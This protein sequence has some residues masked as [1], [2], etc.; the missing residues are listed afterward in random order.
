MAS[1]G[2]A[3]VPAGSD[4]F[5]VL[6]AR[7]AL[8]ILAALCCLIAL[9][10]WTG[11]S[12]PHTK[13]GPPSNDSAV[14][15][16]IV[17][18]LQQGEDYYPAALRE[19][20][21]G[22]Y[23]LKPFLTVRLPTLALAAAALP[24]PAV[25]QA[26]AG[27]LAL[28]T[29]AAWLW[30]LRGWMARPFSF[31]AMVVV[32]ILALVPAPIGDDYTFHELWCG[33]LMALALAVYSP[34][35][36]GI[37]FVIACLALSLRELT[38][39]FFLAMG[40]LAWRDGRRAEAGA[41]GFAL[42]VFF[43]ALALHAAAVQPWVKPDDPPSAGWLGLGGWQFLLLLTKWNF[44]LMTAPDWLPAVLLPLA[45]FGLIARRGSWQDRLALTVLGYSFTFLVV[46]RADNS[47]WGLL[48][49]P[50]WPVGLVASGPALLGLLGKVRLQR[51]F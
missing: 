47:Y 3:S 38:A 7:G 9:G 36:W 51:A 30:R 26:L 13:G 14:F 28:L 48:L 33:E 42:L 17:A 40:V 50:L 46:G 27:A 10:L 18:D 1:S 12:P 32:M 31:S 44:L 49:T 15:L 21:A 22:D 5:A 23:P 43:G 39:P 35:R 16:R 4:R 11:A 8:A 37:S 41:W 6:G 2:P 45:L 25:R 24:D 34:R 29:L 19:L 20:R